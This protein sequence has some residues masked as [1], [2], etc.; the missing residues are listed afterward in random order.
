[1][2]STIPPVYPVKDLLKERN[3]GLFPALCGSLALLFGQHPLML[4]HDLA[5]PEASLHIL[6]ACLNKLSFAA[7][8]NFVLRCR[9]QLACQQ[10]G[11]C[12]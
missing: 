7:D 5:G 4:C 9:V 12:G 8:R 6:D 1:M 11:C 10:K 2:V 3:F